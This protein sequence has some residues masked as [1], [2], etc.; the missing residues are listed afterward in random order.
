MKLTL[1]EAI[2]KG[3]LFIT[4]EILEKTEKQRDNY[5]LSSIL[6]CVCLGFMCVVTFLISLQ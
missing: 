1:N 4:N 6:L 2:L 5:R 3:Q